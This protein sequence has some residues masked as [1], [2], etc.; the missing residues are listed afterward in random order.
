MKCA[1]IFDLQNVKSEIKTEAEEYDD[2]YVSEEENIDFGHFDGSVKVIFPL[3]RFSKY[4]IR[5]IINL[6]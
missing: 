3:S 5:R 4:C 2:F 6:I 1:F